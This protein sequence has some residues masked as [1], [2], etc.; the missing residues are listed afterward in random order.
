MAAKHSILIVDDEPGIREVL[1]DV[2]AGS[3]CV[4]ETVGNGREALDQIA[5]THFDLVISDF[6]MPEMDG[7][8][9][10]DAIKNTDPALA[11]RMIFVTGDTVSPRSRNFFESTGSRWLSKP[12]NISDVEATVS[13]LLKQAPYTDLTAPTNHADRPIRKYHPVSPPPEATSVHS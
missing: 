8:Q 1:K 2:L 13:A 12:F 7:E 6:C 10:Y 11:R 3:G 4:V 5:A 9:L